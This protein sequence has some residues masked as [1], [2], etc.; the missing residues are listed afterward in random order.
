MPARRATEGACGRA[1]ESGAALLQTALLIGF[2]YLALHVPGLGTYALLVAVTL[3]FGVTLLRRRPPRTALGP[4]LG[5]A[6]LLALY[7]T[8]L[9]LELGVQGVLHFL[10]ILLPGIVFL[11]CWRDGPAL[12]R[13]RGAVALF[14]VAALAML[15]V[16]VAPVGF[17]PNQMA[18]VLAHLSLIVGLLLVA[19]LDGRGWMGGAAFGLAV[20]VGAVYGARSVVLA[21]A[22]GYAVYLWGGI[23]LRDRRGACGLILLVGLAVCFPVTLLGTSHLDGVLPVLDKVARRYTG[24]PI[25]TGREYLWSQA[26]IALSE[27]GWLGRGPGGVLAPPSVDGAAEIGGGSPARDPSCLTGGN[28]GLIE[29]CLALMSARDVLAGDATLWWTYDVPIASWA[30]VTLGG[31]PPRVVGLALEG[32]GLR[33]RVAP[34]LAKLD[35]LVSLRLDD[36]RLGGSIPPAL[37]GLT[38]LRE[39]TLD[40]NRL[41]GPIPPELGELSNLETLWLGANRL[42][43]GIPPELGKLTALESVWLDGNRFS[44][45]VPPALA[46]LERPVVPEA[47]VGLPLACPG[48]GHEAQGGEPGTSGLPDCEG[49]GDGSRRPMTFRDAMRR[50]HGVVDPSARPGSA[51]PP[52]MSAHNVFLQIGLQMGVAGILAAGF[53]CASLLFQLRSRG[54]TDGDTAQRFAAGCTVMVI[55]HST[56]ETFLLTNAL[57][58]SL[59]PWMLLGIGA[60]VV[61]HRRDLQERST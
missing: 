13:A 39:L 32:R 10:G 41:V 28:R 51:H 53:L 6:A 3:A 4:G 19:R 7:G 22:L 36:N 49:F 15:V 25:R 44:G 42:T 59:F 45:G 8:G 56:F 43:G 52:E 2:C 61:D 14:V 33:G 9:F 48:T 21:G 34:D 40:H 24:D 57:I 31:N 35:R 20:V 54:G 30:G 58:V 38:R 23:F 47:S 29:D 12:V 27:S 46:V 18:G 60:G 17:H 11:L 26:L 50:L 16:Y 5:F 1:P 37:G 55:V